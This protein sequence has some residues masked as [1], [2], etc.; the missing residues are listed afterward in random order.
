MRAVYIL[1]I[2][3]IIV[4]SLTVLCILCPLILTTTKATLKGTSPLFIFFAC[5][6][7]GFML[8]EISQMQ[9]LIIFL[10]HPTYSLS[11]VLF[12]LLVSSGLGSYLTQKIEIPG[13]TGAAIRRLL[14]LLCVLVI[15]GIFTEH[16]M[17]TFQQ[18]ATIIR[19]LVASGILF[20][21]GLFM[22]MA[23]PLGMK[24]AS[25]KTDSLTP[26]LWGINGATS[27]CASV[28]AVAIALN[29]GISSSFW[30]GFFCYTIG[31][32]SFTWELWK[33]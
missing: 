30:T 11:V 13:M 7:F 27:V 3:L 12:S 26:W 19:I 2:L 21:I 1:G 23:F 22:G 6:G 8:V 20:P 28:L 31:V 9:R 24:I 33:R 10:G 32:I 25:A 14:L 18:S 29:A 15:F 16:F 17:S 4:T 5:I